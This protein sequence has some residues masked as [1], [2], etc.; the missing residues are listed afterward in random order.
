MSKKKAAPYVMERTVCS[1]CGAVKW[2]KKEIDLNGEFNTVSIVGK[3]R[4]L[5]RDANGDKD[6][7]EK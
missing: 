1:E 5:G 4:P 7:E 6:K 2:V 3:Y